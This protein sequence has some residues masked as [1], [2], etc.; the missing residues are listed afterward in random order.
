MAWLSPF[1]YGSKIQ[2]EALP[3]GSAARRRKRDLGGMPMLLSNN[4]AIGRLR[5]LLRD[6]TESGTHP[7]KHR[8]ML[9]RIGEQVRHTIEPLDS[10]W[11]M[12]SFTCG[13][14][15]FGFERSREYAAIA[16]YGLGRAFA[17]PEFFRWLIDSSRLVE[18][19]DGEPPQGSIIMYFADGRPVHV[20][21]VRTATRVV[22]KWGIGLLYDHE[23]REVPEQYGS[24][25]RFFEALEYDAALDRFIAFA[26]ERGIPIDD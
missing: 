24:E 10:D 19:T 13:M 1:D 8:A 7:S 6:M 12:A 16:G 21:R 5:R 20:G 22:S 23:I 9:A 11:D 15:A 2:T 14:H 26:K 17:G 3:C 4:D 25:V 18:I